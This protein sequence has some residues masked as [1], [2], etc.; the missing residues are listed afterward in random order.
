MQGF[1]NSSQFWQ[2][3]LSYSKNVDKRWGVLVGLPAQCMVL[4]PLFQ[5]RAQG[6]PQDLD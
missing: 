2:R 1:G 6:G 3:D 5:L 4:I